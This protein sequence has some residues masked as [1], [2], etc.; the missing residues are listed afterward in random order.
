[1]Y[2]NQDEEGQGETGTVLL[3]SGFAQSTYDWRKIWDG[4]IKSNRRV[5]A[6]D[7]LGCGFSDKPQ[8]PKYDLALH[9][10]LYEFM[11]Y[12][13]GI[14]DVHILSCDMGNNV[15]SELIAR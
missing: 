9:A 5:V 8:F 3:I 11:M 12:E 7:M 4:L 2:L 14:Q 1:M 6:I 15:A 13:L 10:D